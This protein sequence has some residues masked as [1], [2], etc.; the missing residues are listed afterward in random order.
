M[1]AELCERNVHGTCIG[2]FP[3]SDEDVSFVHLKEMS[4]YLVIIQIEKCIFFFHLFS[5]KKKNKLCKYLQIVI[6]RV[7]LPG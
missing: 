5:I 7:R 3:G 2:R 6:E 1:F 4:T